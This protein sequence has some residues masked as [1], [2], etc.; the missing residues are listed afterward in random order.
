MAINGLSTNRRCE[1]SGSCLFDA[2][3]RFV[4]RYHSRT[5]TQPEK[6]LH[7]REAALL[8]RAGLD[9]ACVYQ[10]RAR[11]LADFGAERG[12]QDAIADLR[13]PGGPACGQR[14]LL[15]GG[16]GL[17]RAADPVCGGAVL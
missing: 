6:R 4:V 14:R 1:A 10:D 16:R 13:R 2:G 17:Q 5:T 9:I 12:E 8:A 7:P 3:R 11:T 15:R